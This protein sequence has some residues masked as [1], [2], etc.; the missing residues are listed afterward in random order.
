MKNKLFIV[1]GT[2]M[3]MILAGE[4]LLPRPFVQGADPAP[5]QTRLQF[6][7]SEK[8]V[9]EKGSLSLQETA[10]PVKKPV[11]RKQEKE[12]E[13][14]TKPSGIDSALPGA[15]TPSAKVS[16]VKVSNPAPAAGAPVLPLP[17]A[18]PASEKSAVP[19]DVKEVKGNAADSKKKYDP[20]AEN[21]EYFVGWEKPRLALVLSG[22]LNG[23]IE[24]CGCAG[25]ERM[26]GGLSRRHSFIR[27]LEAKDWPI[28][29][30]DAGQVADGF[31]VQKELK[32]DMAVNAF[33]LMNYR[34]ISIG[35]N[36][37][38]FPAY[39]LLTFTAPSGLGEPSL[40]FSA[41][42]A[43]YSFHRLYTLPYKVID[44][45][46]MRIG[47]TSVVVPN[48]DLSHRD[49]NILIEDPA[50][51]LKE[52]LPELKEA[53]CDKLILIVHGTEKETIDLAAKFPE[54]SI[55]ITSDSP[56][57]PPA[58]LR[59]INTDQYLIEL[60]EKGKYTAV[61]GLYSDPA[62]PVKYQRVALDSRFE[63]SK[64]VHLLMEEY[65]KILKTLI[66]E[67]GYKNGLGLSLVESPYQAALGSYVGSAKCESCHEESYRIWR[68]NKHSTAWNSLVKTADPPRDFD[69]ECISCHVVGWHGTGY[70]PYAGGFESE[71][72]TPHLENVGCE[73]CHGPGSRHIEAEMGKD[74]NLQDQIRKGMQL[75]KNAKKVCFSCHDNDNSP[76]F[77][78]DSYYKII[79]H[80]ENE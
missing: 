61:L 4:Y 71:K 79:E 29:S 70:F 36:E 80:K 56:S 76:E 58:E 19:K 49:E 64:D 28:A 7:E 68:R 14:H 69:P 12:T 39:F 65:Q 30:I 10:A 26:K 59:K 74:E 17:S 47:V 35:A 24:P 46:G 45:N 40:F 25:M 42:V 67:K 44:Q 1:L 18:K 66:T 34:A 60:G 50:Q 78:Y 5:G 41:N 11:F 27:D 15:K 13:I 2:L 8:K 3:S 48:E 31:G 62:H 52:I 20:I 53:Q 23:Y 21:G 37:L 32:F 54:F 16:A 75:G 38:K 57:T 73:S 51:K 43:V 55:I 22:L 63:Q 33:H 77:E 6:L 9:K 72:T